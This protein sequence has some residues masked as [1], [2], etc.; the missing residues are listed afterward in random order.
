MLQSLT[1]TGVTFFRCPNC[2]RKYQANYFDMKADECRYQ[3][4]CIWCGS[5]VT[6]WNGGRQYAYF[7]PI[8]CGEHPNDFGFQWPLKATLLD[9]PSN[10]ASKTA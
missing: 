2:K 1:M 6:E 10:T 8:E 5:L 7:W 4:D 3:F 9:P